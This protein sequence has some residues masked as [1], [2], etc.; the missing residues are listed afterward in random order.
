MGV[1]RRC[2]GF[3]WH[4]WFDFYGLKLFLSGTCRFH[5]YIQLCSCWLGISS[6]RL[7][8]FSEHL[9][10][11][12]RCMVKDLMVVAPLKI[13]V[14]LYFAWVCLYCSL[15]P[16]IYGMTSLVPSINFTMDGFGFLFFFCWCLSCWKNCGG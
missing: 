12:L 10:L 8:Q 1:L 5:W 9:E 11:D 6:G 13:N 3:W 7:Y 15:R 14:T 2:D 4:W 16:L